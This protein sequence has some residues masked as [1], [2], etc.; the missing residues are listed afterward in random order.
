MQLLLSSVEF[1]ILYF[2]ILFILVKRSQRKN[3]L[4]AHRHIYNE[5]EE[6]VQK[7][8]SNGSST[9]P[10]EAAKFPSAFPKLKDNRPPL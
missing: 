7:A 6:A 3:L 9:T 10:T 8:V 2:C 5:A 1:C 4:A